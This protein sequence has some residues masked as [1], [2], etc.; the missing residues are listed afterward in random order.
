MA[1]KAIIIG[2]GIGGLMSAMAL[3]HA[4][5]E[6]TVLDRDPPPPDTSPDDVFENWQHSGVGHVRHSH[7]FLA[8]LYVLIRDKYPELLGDLLS[9]GCRILPF[10]NIIPEVSRTRFTPRPSDDNLNILT[11]RR[12]TLELIMRRF[13]ERLPHVRIEP[14]V[15]VRGLE[16][17]RNDAG[18]IIVTGVSADLAD[19]TKQE[20]QPDFIVDASGKNAPAMDWLKE[21][22]L[23]IE[24]E[25]EPAGILYFTRHYRLHDGQDEPARGSSPTSGDLGYI[26]FG[27]FP[28]DNRRFS[29]TLAIPEIEME[30]RKAAV[31]PSAFDRICLSMPGMAPWVDLTRSEPASRVFGMGELISRWRHMVKDDQPKVLNYFPVGDCV[32]RTNPLYGRGC[33]FAAISA[34]LLSD[35]LTAS[36][37]P[38]V[39]ARLYHEGVTRE[40][41]P[42]YDSMVS[43]DQTAIRRA[44]NTL[45]P[46]YK[47]R[48]KTR[49]IKSFIEDGVV[50]ATR[51]NVDLM[52]RAMGAFHMMES[53]NAW[54]KEP[55]NFARILMYWA[56]GKWLN[57]KYYPANIG[58]RRD[59][60]FA[61]IG[62]SATADSQRLKAI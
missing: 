51:A 23:E 21:A 45:D 52:R 57:A 44:R 35:A 9:A 25:T 22:G 31:D 20:W 33:S 59:Q 55:A 38:A 62:L 19:G 42:F 58:P 17:R 56:R 49:L 8:R 48:F 41:R 13:V 54:L 7:A 47:P 50:I 46:D 24:E 28:A 37:D 29:V 15:K 10:E 39:R 16:T 30:L 5:F 34:H 60:L 11:S 36:D 18:Q 1:E 6:V 4:G 12:T 3:G 61:R 53:P 27:I 2:A 43:Q 32:I 14:N 26:K 40:L